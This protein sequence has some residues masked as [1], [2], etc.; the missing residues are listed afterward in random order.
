MEKKQ[1][2]EKMERR[3]PSEIFLAY[4]LKNNMCGSLATGG[5]LLPIP[6]HIMCRSNKSS[7]TIK[8]IYFFVFSLYCN[9]AKREVK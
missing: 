1:K 3:G 9:V 7:K 5:P 6:F 2:Q 8:N 4:C